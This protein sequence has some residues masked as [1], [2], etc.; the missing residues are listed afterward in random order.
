MTRRGVR[1]TRCPQRLATER[2]IRERGDRDL[3]NVQDAAMAAFTSGSID[4]PTNSARMRERLAAVEA[5]ADKGAT[6]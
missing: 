2:Y 1:S 5:Q 3:Q 4:A 6:P